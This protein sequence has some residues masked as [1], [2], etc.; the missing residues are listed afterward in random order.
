MRYRLRTLLIVLALVPPLL[1]MGWVKWQEYREYLADKHR[2][3]M[4]QR[5]AP[6]I[7]APRPARRPRLARADSASPLS[8]APMP[9]RIELDQDR[10]EQIRRQLEVID[11]LMSQNR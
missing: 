2:R 1:A 7:A 5:T 11:K 9:A 6:A 8:P 3:E 4:V 10:E